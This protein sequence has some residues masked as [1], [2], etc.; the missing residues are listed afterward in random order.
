MIRAFVGIAIPEHVA[1][2]LVAAQAGLPGRLIERENFHLTLAFL[3]DVPGPL[4]EEVHYALEGIYA[5]GFALMLDGADSFGRPQPAT[6]HL[7]VAPQPDLSHLR[8]KIA[9][10]V[11]EAG[12]EIDGRRFTP[13]VT[14]ARFGSGLGPDDAL[15]LAAWIGRRAGLRAGPFAVHEFTL[16]RSHLGRKGAAYEALESYPLAPSQAAS[17]IS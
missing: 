12:A 5:P 13:H 16:F 11:R 7:R 3:G 17:A 15:D 8:A 1:G 9:R 4:L 2:A 10:A 14:L 6:A